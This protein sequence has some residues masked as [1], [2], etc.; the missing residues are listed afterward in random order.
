MGEG[1]VLF[2]S[3]GT[4]ELPDPQGQ[5]PLP[6]TGL[7][8]SFGEKANMGSRERIPDTSCA[9]SLN[10]ATCFLPFGYLS[11]QFFRI[12][13]RFSHLQGILAASELENRIDVE[14]GDDN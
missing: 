12:P 13:L 5:Q 4:T 3:V 11:P 10:S 7:W 6:D 8:P 2:T 14:S 9:L 1:S